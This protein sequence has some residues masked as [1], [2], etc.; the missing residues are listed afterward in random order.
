MLA[1]AGEPGRPRRRGARRPRPHRR[2]PDRVRRRRAPPLARLPPP[3][4]PAPA[5][6]LAATPLPRLRGSRRRLRPRRR[7][8]APAGPRRRVP[9]GGGGRLRHGALPRPAQEDAPAVPAGLLGVGVV[10]VGAAAVPGDEALPGFGAWDRRPV[11]VGEVAGDEELGVQ[12]EC[13]VL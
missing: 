1:G 7:S 6:A 9:G 12:V 13:A 3:R 8:G 4:R 11:G 10:G 5:T 2:R